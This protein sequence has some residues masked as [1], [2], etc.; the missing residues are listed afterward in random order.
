[1]GEAGPVPDQ[2]DALEDFALA[3]RQGYRSNDAA[4]GSIEPLHRLAQPDQPEN[5]R[6]EEQGHGTKP[7]GRE[8]IDA[9]PGGEGSE[10]VVGRDQLILQGSEVSASLT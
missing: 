6:I 2:R 5:T 1:M 4:P 7:D 8:T 10:E 9:D 3:Q